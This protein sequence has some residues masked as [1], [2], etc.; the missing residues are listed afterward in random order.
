LLAALPAAPTSVAHAFVA[1]GVEIPDAVLTHV[2]DQAL[3]G[4]VGCGVAVWRQTGDAAPVLAA[5][6]KQFDERSEI[7]GWHLSHA[8]P[9]GRAF[10]PY[11]PRLREF[12]T[13]EASARD[14]GLQVAAA[15]LVWLATGDADGVRPTAGAVLAARER[16]C[17][18]AARLLWQMGS[19]PEDLVPAVLGATR[20]GHAV[21]DAIALLVEM[22]A[23]TAVPDLVRLAEQDERIRTGGNGDDTVWNDEE[24]QRQLRA[25]VR[26]LEA[27]NGA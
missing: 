5:V 22:R 15:H 13:G 14:Q 27:L 23:T 1:I 16:S 20:Y 18:A 10:G 2:R 19:A 12:L 8:I 6:G 25:A 9:A 7:M 17:V 24:V 21:F 11:V 3:A 4:E 26:Q